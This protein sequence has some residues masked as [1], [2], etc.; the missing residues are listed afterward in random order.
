M[1]NEGR[2][3]FDPI[4]PFPV[5]RIFEWAC[6]ALAAA[7]LFAIMVLTFFDVGGR[8]FA[9]ASI[10]GSLEVT[11]LLMVIVIF[12]ALP[13]VSIRREHVVFDS[14]DHVLS[15]LL[16]RVQTMLVNLVCGALLMALAYL[17]WR[18]AG[19]FAES[20]ETTAQLKLLKA[21]FIYGMSVL[22]GLTGLVH[23]LRF[24]L[25]RPDVPAPHGGDTP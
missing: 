12:A 3:F 5:N 2:I 8:K 19:E 10:P 16:R 25:R 21:P 15:P 4:R 23:L 18:T 6:G 17:M 9:S 22:C 24:V 14:L 7:A 11:E 1:H 13:L 20:G